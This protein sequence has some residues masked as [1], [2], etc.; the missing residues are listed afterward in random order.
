MS[1]N[2][3]GKS[4]LKIVLAIETAIL[5]GVFGWMG[6]AS[7]EHGK[8]IATQQLLIDELRENKRENDRAMKELVKLCQALHDQ[9]VQLKYE[10]QELKAAKHP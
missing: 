8:A 1:H 2:E 7:V 6:T 3:N 4:A 9:D 5:L 10:I